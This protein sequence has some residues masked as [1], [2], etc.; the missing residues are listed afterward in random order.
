MHHANT[1]EITRQQQ[2]SNYRQ[3]T[4]QQ[5]S[6]TAALHRRLCRNTRVQFVW[7]SSV[8]VAILWHW[9]KNLMCTKMYKPTNQAT[10]FKAAKQR[11]N[12]CTT[13]HTTHVQH[14]KKCD[15][16]LTAA[17]E[18]CVWGDRRDTAESLRQPHHNHTKCRHVAETGTKKTH[19]SIFDLRDALVNINNTQRRQHTDAA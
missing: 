18:M 3:P 13:L 5:D 11:S 8:R 12:I 14:K 9:S 16:I 17:H 7:R 10:R 15:R 1:H 4:R 6:K 2:Q 19:T